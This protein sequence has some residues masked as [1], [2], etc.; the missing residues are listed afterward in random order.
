[1]RF[2]IIDDDEFKAN[3]AKNILNGHETVVVGSYQSGMKKIVTEAW[4]GI[5]LDM[6]FPQFDD[7]TDYEKD[8]GLDILREMKR[9]AIYIPVVVHSGSF[10]KTD[11]FETVVD[12]VV[13][14]PTDHLKQAIEDLI[15]NTKLK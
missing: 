13:S 10:F 9:R 14:G 15:F 11:D 7:G 6:G 5:I 4:D 8:K 1:M 3:C 2:L 12:Y